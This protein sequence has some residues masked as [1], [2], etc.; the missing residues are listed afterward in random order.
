ME[1]FLEAIISG[2]R[3][4]YSANNDVRLRTGLGPTGVMTRIIKIEVTAMSSCLRILFTLYAEPDGSEKRE[5]SEK[6]LTLYALPHCVPPPIN[7]TR[8]Q[9]PCVVWRVATG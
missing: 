8:S 6:R 3:F 5:V 1:S 7:L 4:A 9:H 2:Y